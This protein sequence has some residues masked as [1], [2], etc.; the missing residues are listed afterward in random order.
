M[1]NKQIHEE[2]IDMNT[3]PK[4][5]GKLSKLNMPKISFKNMN[6]NTVLSLI[7]AGVLLLVGATTLFLTR[8]RG[9]DI[10]S[11][12]IVNSQEL[13]LEK[14]LSATIKQLDGSFQV[15]TTEGDWQDAKKEDSLAEGYSV[16]TVGAASRL[17]ITF[18]D[19]SELRVDANS[20]VSLETVRDGRVVIKHLA[21][22][23]YNRVVPSENHTYIVTSN[24]AKYEAQGT[25]FKTIATGDE[26]AVEVFQSTVIET[27]SNKSPKSGQ[28]LIVKSR[29]APTTSGKIE[30][31]DIEKL[32]ADIFI[33]WNRE[34]DAK[35]DKFKNDLGFLQDITP[36]EITLKVGDGD[37]VFLDPS[38]TEGTIEISGNTEASAKVTALSKSQSGSQPV[39][40][41]VGTDGSF[42]TPVLSAP[43]GSSV[44]EFVAKDR[45]GNTTT[46]TLRVTFQRKSQPVIGSETSSITLTATKVGGDKVKFKWAYG[47]GTTAP[48]G[49]KLVY[50]K[51]EDP[52]YKKAGTTA[53]YYPT[54]TEDTLKYSDDLSLTTG[55]TYYFKV[56]I[57]D[58]ASDACRPELYSTQVTVKP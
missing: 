21:G 25:A 14:T 57:Y 44:F 30:S 32:K 50:S 7:L 47:A 31:L 26:Q 4:P 49:V 27:N 58:T 52:V 55:E 13:P 53:R 11:E 43:L 29:V 23:T 34:L 56:C 28:K 45:T 51:T 8:N 10:A 33:T 22:Y 5:K 54:A 37:V 41:T 40:I 2:N 39:E 35:D 9:N 16:R 48:E 17:V 15:K 1:D 12:E 18:E 20:E 19:G 38:A 36:P 6:K 24:D 46:K 42:T 3:E